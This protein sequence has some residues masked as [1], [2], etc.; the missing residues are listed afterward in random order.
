MKRSRSHFDTTK[1]KEK[2]RKAMEKGKPT[3][4][5]EEEEYKE[6]KVERQQ[7]EK[8]KKKREEGGWL[9]RSQPGL[10][11]LRSGEEFSLFVST[12]DSFRAV[13]ADRRISVLA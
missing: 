11:M 8:E 13:N 4:E 10:D 2:E 1:M 9:W 3:K 12:I 6:A 7:G 5:D